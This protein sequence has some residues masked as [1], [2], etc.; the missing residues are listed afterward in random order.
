MGARSLVVGQ[1]GPS[2]FWTRNPVRTCG[3]SPA[4]EVRCTPFPGV[5]MD[6]Y[7]PVEVSIP[8]FDCGMYL[9]RSQ[10]PSCECSTDIVIGSSHWLLHPMGVPWQ[11]RVGM[12]L[13]DCGM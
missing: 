9:P 1:M 11:A 7:S 4:I 13:S 6:A 2:S 8:I 5:L 3:P 12:A 10:S